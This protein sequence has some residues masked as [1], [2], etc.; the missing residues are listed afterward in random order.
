MKFSNKHGNP[1][2]RLNYL[3]DLIFDYLSQVLDKYTRADD[4]P[5]ESGA[6]PLLLNKH[7]RI[8]S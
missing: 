4:Q 7:S 5:S 3:I 1:Q 2:I 8:D 6:L